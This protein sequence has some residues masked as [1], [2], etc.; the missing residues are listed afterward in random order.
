M[1]GGC[2]NA[3]RQGSVGCRAAR[4][5]AA[6]GHGAPTMIQASASVATPFPAA[7]MTLLN[8][9][10]ACVALLL[11]VAFALHGE[12]TR[13]RPFFSVRC[14]QH[15]AAVASKRNGPRVPCTRRHRATTSGAGW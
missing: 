8:P 6:A 3:E 2:K 4:R 10:R 11:F 5:A 9:K 7:I 1:A 12:W 15:A 14:M 13:D